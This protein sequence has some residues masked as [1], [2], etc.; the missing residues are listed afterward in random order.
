MSGFFAKRDGF[1]DQYFSDAEALQL[2]VHDKPAQAGALGVG[3][4]TVDGDS[5]GKGFFRAHRPETIP[6]FTEVDK[7]RGE[8]PGNLGFEGYVKVPVFMI[9]DCVKLGHFADY[10][11]LIAAP[12]QLCRTF[13]TPVI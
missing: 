5:T 13:D 6:P 11:G 7:K 12:F 2:R 1:F 8:F 9:L 3:Q 10:A 4:L